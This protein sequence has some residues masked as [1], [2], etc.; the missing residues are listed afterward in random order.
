M[1]NDNTVT[2]QSYQDKTDEYINGTPA[3][4]ECIKL[5]PKDTK[6]LEIGSGFGRDADYFRERGVTIECS[7]A[8]PNFVELLQQKG[9]HARLLNVLTDS[10]PDKY[11]LI[12][13]DAVLLHFSAQEVKVVIEKVYAA[14]ESGGIFAFRIKQGDGEEWTEAKLGAPRYFRYW[15]SQDIRLVAEAAGFEWVDL[16]VAEHNNNTWLGI[17]CRKP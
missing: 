8:V 17:I 1:Q 15:Q 4:D 10:I 9:F 6:T 7:D 16:Q 2:L 14:L 3:I 11:G 13:A 12:F 5:T